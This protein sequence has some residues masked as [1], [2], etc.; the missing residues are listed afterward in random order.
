VSDENGRFYGVD[1]R[2]GEVVW[3]AQTR[4]AS[5]AAAVGADGTVYALQAYGPALIAIAEDGQ[6]RWE[7]D[8]E[9]LAEAALPKSL[10]LGEPSAIGNGNPTVVDDQI[11]VPIVYGFETRMFGR[12]IPWPVTSSLVAVDA[13][14][15]KGV[16]NVLSLADDST[17]IT[18][19][20]PDGSI[21]NSL[22]TAMTSGAT[23]LAGLAR[24]LLPGDLEPL[25]P[26]G[27][28]QVSRPVSP[29]AASMRD[30]MSARLALRSDAHRRDDATRHPLEVLEFAGIREGMRVAELMAG[31]GWYAEVLARAVGPKGR[32]LAQNNEVSASRYGK[33]LARRLEAQGLEAIE[34]RV[35]ELD[36][37]GLES[38]SFDAVF[39]VKFYHDTVWM[40]VDRPEMLRRIRDSL[41]PD[42]VFLVV[43]HA[44]EAGVGLTEVSGL[45]RIEEATLIAE[46]EAAG[47]R[48]AA[49]SSLLANSGDDRTSNVFRSRVR[50]NTD[51]F[52]LRFDPAK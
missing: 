46:V 18:V 1:A 22:G 38:E 23:P 12:R 29:E 37:L 39:L 6:V 33:D 3:E 48:L 9:A 15:G 36:A 35:E 26:L 40:G 47:F 2:T 28:F 45:H 10:M 49:R 20:L 17:G 21:V 41:T 16:R 42:G 11:L 4:A 14:T 52:L 27:G 31:G 13:K 19:V 25:L 30:V 7:S 50:G 5:A 34:S 44:A 32:V 43:D 24:L 51:R 8:L